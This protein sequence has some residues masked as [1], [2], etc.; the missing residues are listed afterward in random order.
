MIGN[1]MWILLGVIFGIAACLGTLLRIVIRHKID[2]VDWFTFAF[3]SFNGFSFS[4]IIWVTYNGQNDWL[5]TQW[6]LGHRDFYG[7][8]LASSLLFLLSTWAGATLQ[9]FKRFGKRHRNVSAPKQSESSISTSMSLISWAMLFIAII[10]YYVYVKG[11][12]GFSNL[13]KFAPFIRSGRFDLIAISNPWTFLERFGSFSFFSSFVFFGL[14][15]SNTRDKKFSLSK[16]IGFIISFALSLTILYI[17]RGRLSLVSYLIVFPIGFSL[18]R[19]KISFKTILILIILGII[20]VFL[21]I[22]Q[23]N[24]ILKRGTEIMD[25]S[26]FYASQMSFPYVSFF[27]QMDSGQYRFMEDVVL[28]PIYILPDRI[29]K[30]LLHIETAS[31]VNTARIKGAIK[32]EGSSVTGEVPVDILTFAFMQ[33]GIVGLFAVGF[34]WGI[35]LLFVDSFIGLVPTGVKEA[36]YAFSIINI[37][38]LTIPYGDSRHFLLEN[39][40]FV[41]GIIAFYMFGIIRPK[42]RYYGATEVENS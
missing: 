37:S 20:A 15:L 8:Y 11:Y 38:I 10:S 5:W 36:L 17:R 40:Y 2:L 14:V 16:L 21:I 33:G 29:F 35:F 24:L 9:D 34:L 6:I 23:A 31:D 13:L 7:I 1:E 19:Y 22:P 30:G 32:G 42:N 12:G 3:G 39:I 25:I 18:F 28:S 4:F 27:A 26:Q 41:V